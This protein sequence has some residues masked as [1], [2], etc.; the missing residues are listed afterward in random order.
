MDL[1]DQQLSEIKEASEENVK[2][3]SIASQQH[4][5]EQIQ[6]AQAS[7]LN[8]PTEADHTDQSTALSI[9]VQLSRK[10]S[11]NSEI[12]T[13]QREQQFCTN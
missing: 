8:D 6:S 4:V 13:V 10:I 12:N 11:N 7:D 9:E 1:N 5:D 2:M 3:T